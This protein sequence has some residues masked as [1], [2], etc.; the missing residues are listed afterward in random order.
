MSAE[1]PEDPGE[2]EDPEEAAALAR[3]LRAWLGAWP[4]PDEGITVV[5]SRRREEPAWDG[6]LHPV[7]GVVSP[8]G[9]VVSVPRDR[10]AAVEAAIHGEGAVAL[11]AAMGRPGAR[12]IDGIFRW[13]TRPTPFPD[14]G[15]W[16]PVDDP[17]VPDWLHPFGGEVLVALE[18]G[19]Y[20]A[21]VGLK[22][23][24]PTGQEVAVVTEEAARGKGLARGLVCQAARRVV[25]TGA[26][27][28]YLHAPTNVASAHVA[29]AC[30]FPDRGW[31]VLGLTP[32]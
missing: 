19:R 11:P 6:K 9:G 13:S 10:V 14:V 30:G 5:G 18:D 7:T 2:P 17:V 3:H 28:T 25:A 24:D 26:V 21:G 15:V 8:A 32:G 22:R 4:P 1:N 12:V 20:I 27:V 16:L 23:H 29:D 31:R